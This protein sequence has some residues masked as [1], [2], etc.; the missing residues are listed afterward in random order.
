MRLSRRVLLSEILQSNRYRLLFLL[1]SKGKIEAGDG[2]KARLKRTFGYQS[3]SAFYNDWKFF[4][5][6]GLVREDERW[7]RITP[8]GKRELLFL[9]TPL[10]IGVIAIVYALIFLITMWMSTAGMSP[11]LAK[12][13]PWLTGFF[14]FIVIAFLSLYTYRIL[15]PRLSAEE[16]ALQ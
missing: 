13:S 12:L 4:L 8:K 2:T 9:G 6:E 14:P 11:I 16:R 5:S 1:Y 3:D 15:R 10:A 7:I